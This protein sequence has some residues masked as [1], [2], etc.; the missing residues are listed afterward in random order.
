MNR[1]KSLLT[2]GFFCVAVF[3]L[4]ASAEASPVIVRMSVDSFFGQVGSDGQFVTYLDNG[5]G[6][7]ILCPDAGC[8]TGI[9]PASVALG[10][11]NQVEF[12]NSSFGVDATHNLISFVPSGVN[13][14]DLGKEF[15]LGT[16]T[17]TN[18]IWFTDPEFGVTFSASST[19]L[20]FV[21]SWS[22]TVHLS[23]TP[24][25]PTNTPEQN[26]DL[27]YLTGLPSLGSVRAYELG[28]SPL[29]NKV[30]AKVYGRISSLDL[31]R[32]ADATGGGF[33]NPSISLQ[34]TPPTEVPEPA[35][36]ALLSLGL[37]GLR[38]IRRRSSTR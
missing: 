35:T 23:I 21:Q 27:I 6:P 7:E 1:Q 20:G 10:G 26:A 8:D 24:N 14:V 36:L 3:V 4:S 17:Y 37:V 25:L 12:W 38:W 9:G 5:S 32:F 16:I 2:F 19:D 28:A 22:S 34:P 33:L 29:G 30:S 18:G 31:T 15:L 11:G 13:D